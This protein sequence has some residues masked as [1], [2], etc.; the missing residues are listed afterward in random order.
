MAK[1]TGKHLVSAAQRLRQPNEVLSGVLGHALLEPL[2]K[3]LTNSGHSELEV[4]E[5]VKELLSNAGDPNKQTWVYDALEQ[6]FVDA[7][8]AG[9]LDSTPAVLEA[10]R[11]S[12]SIA[13]LLGTLG[14]AVVFP[15]DVELER[16]EAGEA[17][18]YLR[19]AGEANP[20][21]ERG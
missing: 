17:H 2:R 15:R 6:K 11:N 10:L 3:L 8:D 4:D 16:R 12:I 18:S 5:I 7:F 9:V 13:S 20:A 14:G 19:D 21:D 1:D